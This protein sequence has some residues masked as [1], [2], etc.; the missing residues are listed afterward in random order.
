MPAGLDGNPGIA[1]GALTAPV[2]ETV[3]YSTRPV[4]TFHQAIFAQG[5]VDSS[6]MATPGW[7]RLGAVDTTRRLELDSVRFAIVDALVPCR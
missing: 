6:V 4:P 3:E 7:S 2:G 1:A 5:P